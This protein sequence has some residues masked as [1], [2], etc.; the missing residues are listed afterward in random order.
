MDDPAYVF[1]SWSAQALIDPLPIAGGEGAW[2][3]DHEGNRYLDGSS[4]LVNLNLGHQHP[5]IVEAIKAQADRLCTVA[6]TFANDVR[7][8]AARMIVERAGAGFSKVFFTNGGAEA[9]ENAVRM[10]KVHTGRHKVLAH[11]RSYHGATHGSIALTG[12]PRRWPSEP[13]LPGVVHFH[14]PYPYRSS[15]GATTPE[16]ETERALAHLDEVLMYEGAHTVAAVIVESVV[17]TNGILVP[18]PGYLAGLA[19]RCRAHGILLICDEV[20]AGF[21]RCGAWFAF[22]RFDVAARPHLLRQGRELR[23]RPARRRGDQRGGRRHLRRA[24]LPGWAHLLGPPARLRQRGGVDAGVRGRGRPRPRRRARAGGVGPRPRRAG[25]R[26]TRRWARCAA[27]AA[28]G[29]SSSCATRPPASR[30][31]PTTRRAPRRRRW[32]SWSPP[33]RRAGSGPSP[34]S[35]GCTWS[36]RS[37]SPWTTRGCSSDI[38]DTAL[39]VADA[40]LG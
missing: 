25:G 17:G 1:H 33:A 26:S 31:S 16:E 7:G 8:Q 14:G 34:T 4:Q 21:G 19:E 35:T 32:P 27:S 29:P 2:F 12:D 5:A 30:W 9:T 24:R 40:H 38:L 37:S 39:D 13:S 11:Y 20:M 28:S 22:Q 15:F 36:R 10:A 3:W 6:P 23:V 18:P